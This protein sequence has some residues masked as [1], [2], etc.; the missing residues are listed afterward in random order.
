MFHLFFFLFLPSLGESSCSFYGGFLH[1]VL[2][3]IVV[4]YHIDGY[5]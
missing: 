4:R 5:G 2:D 3:T 1:L